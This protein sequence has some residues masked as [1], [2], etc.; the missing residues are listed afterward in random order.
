S[1]YRHSLSAGVSRRARNNPAFIETTVDD[2]TLDRLDCDRLVDHPAYARAFARRR[3]NP[4]REF[5]KVVRLV[6]KV[7]RR[8]PVAAENQ[9]VPVR[10]QVVEW[11]TGR[12]TIQL[13]TC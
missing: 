1:D 2:R 6:Q 5:R 10:N 11:T 12:S 13:F 4:P 8:F 9:I 3:T 7:E